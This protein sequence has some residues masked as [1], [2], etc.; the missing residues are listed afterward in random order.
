VCG[1]QWRLELYGGFWLC[2][3]YPRRG[4]GACEG[5]FVGVQWKHGC[6]GGTWLEGVMEIMVGQQGKKEREWSWM[7]CGGRCMLQCWWLVFHA[8]GGVAE[9]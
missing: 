5:G 3:R 6:Y 1:V 2:L 8:Y 9:V 7:V 4:E